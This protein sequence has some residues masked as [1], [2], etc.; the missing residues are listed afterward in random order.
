VPGTRWRSRENRR[1]SQLEPARRMPRIVRCTSLPHAHAAV[2]RRTLHVA[3][4][5]LSRAAFIFDLTSNT[6]SRYNIKH[7]TDGDLPTMGRSAG[8]RPRSAER[9]RLERSRC[10]IAPALGTRHRPP[11]SRGP[12]LP[13]GPALSCPPRP[14][15]PRSPAV[16][17]LP[18]LPCPAV[19]PVDKVAQA[20]PDRYI[21]RGCAQAHDRRG[22]R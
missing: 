2:T 4:C 13:A 17:V 12:A 16:P 8:R 10:A 20:V 5:Q 15:L 1:P 11:A 6:S 3:R 9:L 19:T 14:P 22:S 21:F 18:A 7:I